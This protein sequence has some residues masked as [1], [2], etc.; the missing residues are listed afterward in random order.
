[1]NKY[2][3]QIFS[4][5]FNKISFIALI[6]FFFAASVSTFAATRTWD[7][8]KS[9]DWNNGQNWEGGKVPQSRDNV[10]IPLG[11][12]YAYSPVITSDDDISIRSLVINSGGVLTMNGGD[13]TLSRNLNNSG[14]V[15]LNSG[16]VTFDRRLN[17]YSGADFIANGATV[18]I[19]GV[20]T[21]EGTMDLNSGSVLLENRTRNLTSGE[22]N[23]AGA[24]VVAQDDVI[25]NGT[26]SISSGSLSLERRNGVP[27]HLL[28]IDG[29]TFS[30]T[31]G[32]V[33]TKELTV[34]NNGIF[35]QDIGVTFVKDIEIKNGGVY[36]QS[37][38]ALII[39]HDFKVPTGNTFTSTG[40]IVQF[41]GSSGPGADYTGSVQFHHIVIDEGVNPKFDNDNGVNIS[42]SGN[43]TNDNQNLDV[44][45]AAFIFNGTG[46]AI[47]SAS[48]YYM[49]T[50]GHLTI[51]N[52]LVTMYSDLA[53]EI[54]L[55][56]IEKLD[57]NGKLL[58]V[59]GVPVP[60]ELTSFT[61][62][63][64][65]NG[66]MLN[67]ATATEVNNYGFSVERA[68]TS[69][70]T[71]S[72]PSSRAESRE[73]VKISFIEGH[74]NSNSPKQYSFYDNSPLKGKALYRLKQIDTDG[75]FEYSDEVEITFLQ[76][77]KIELFQNHPNPFNPST[78]ISFS[79][80]QLSH[81]SI[82][83]YNAIGQKVVD[84]INEQLDAGYHNVNFDGSELSSGFYFYRLETSNYTKTMKMILLR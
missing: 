36:N 65:K 43:Y 41:T 73:W 47:Y 25:S 69:L 75:V 76:S 30:Q 54:S 22:I 72:N 55:T 83:V 18:T 80:P 50:F 20:V 40:G 34:T 82:I 26:L 45:K 8:T 5:S 24:N 48:P 16:T 74:G 28:K 58:Y 1:M 44:K 11:S 6:I 59:G 9:S 27:N 81:V 21:N 61:A 70:S 12:M 14:N 2:I 31:G 17:N 3:Q 37:S 10:V 60:V 84:I 23:I 33:S 51:N 78:V 13:L 79:L 68:S 77:D 19:S 29:G 7:G 62:K 64:L 38:G 39:D 15:Y 56:G 4:L 42:V 71:T 49:T 66:I 52:P 32:S 35:T 63:I 67:W 46:Q 53:I 57:Q